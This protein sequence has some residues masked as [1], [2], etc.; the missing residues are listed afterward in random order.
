MH[1]AINA[2]NAINMPAIFKASC[3]PSPAPRAAASIR[4]TPGFS[5]SILT[6]PRVSGVPV[7]GMN[8]FDSMM[9]AGAVMMTAVSRCVIVTPA[10]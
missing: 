4:F 7:S 3:K 8:I 2:R 9:V 1:K 10:Q 5:T 6:V